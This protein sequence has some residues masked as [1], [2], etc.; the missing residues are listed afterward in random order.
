MDPVVVTKITLGDT[1]VQNG[2]FAKSRAEVPDPTLFFSASDDWVQ[3]LSIHLL[4]RTDK[5]IAYQ[6]LVCSFPDTTAGRSRAAF[7]LSLGVVPPFAS[8][9]R[10]GT[11]FQQRPGAQPISFGP[12][13]TMTI[14]LGDYIDHIKASVKPGAQ[15]AMQTTMN[16][17]VSI[18]YFAD[19]MMWG[20][21]YMT[22]DRQASKWREV[23]RNSLPLNKDAYWPGR[24]GWP[25]PQ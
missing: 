8:F 16:V 7:E 4:N 22:F 13:Q 9:N 10:D 18:C 21:G 24:P 6:Y 23:D 20:G 2:R 25:D 15:L 11:P 12:H 19:G 17:N 3:K 14:H 5:A 1:V